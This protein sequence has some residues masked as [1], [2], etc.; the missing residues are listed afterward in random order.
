MFFMKTQCPN[1]KNIFKLPAEYVKKNVKCKKCSEVFVGEKFNKPPVV[2]PYLAHQGGNFITKAWL[3][4]PPAFRSGFLVTLGA[5][6]ALLLTFYTM[7]IFN[8]NPSRSLPPGYTTSDYQF[9]PTS[10][11]LSGTGSDLNVLCSTLGSLEMAASLK[12][13]SLSEGTRSIIIS[14]LDYKIKILEFMSMD[15]LLERAKEAVVDAIRAEIDALEFEEQNT[16]RGGSLLENPDYMRLLNKS[17]A[18]RGEAIAEVDALM[19]KI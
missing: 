2:V 6:T 5:L 10:S 7:G 9:Y 19:N 18:L 11:L 4:S 1:C 3:R 14:H 16:G 15:P 8:K 12:F 17:M 13:P